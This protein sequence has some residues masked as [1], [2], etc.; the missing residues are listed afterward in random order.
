MNTAGTRCPVLRVQETPQSTWT[1]CR[2]KEMGENNISRLSEL[3]D[4][5]FQQLLHVSNR[6]NINGYCSKKDLVR[7]RTKDIGRRIF[8]LSSWREQRKNLFPTSWNWNR[9]NFHQHVE[10]SGHVN[11]YLSLCCDGKEFK[12]EAESIPRPDSMPERNE[13]QRN[14]LWEC[15]ISQPFQALVDIT[16]YT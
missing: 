10:I 13:Y 8:Q 4:I 6:K 5:T 12:G 3:G 7:N 14:D 15:P 2:E 1:T 16:V 9:R 11:K